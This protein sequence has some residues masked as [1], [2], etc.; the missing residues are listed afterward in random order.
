[1]WLECV[2]DVTGGAVSRSPLAGAPIA[3]LDF[4][5]HLETAGFVAE[6]GWSDESAAGAGNVEWRRGEIRIRALRDRL[7]WSIWI[8]SPEIGWYHPA[9]WEAYFQESLT[10]PV[11]ALGLEEKCAV[12]LA[13]LDEYGVVA[14]DPASLRGSLQH[15][16]SEHEKQLGAFYKAERERGELGFQS[17]G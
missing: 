14:D 17:N 4:Q 16:R 2:R 13:H 3:L 9:V 12:V 10:A 8:G 5:T 7:Q 6:D 11:R 15:W 1:V